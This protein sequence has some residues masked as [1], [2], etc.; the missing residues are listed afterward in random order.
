MH[1]CVWWTVIDFLEVFLILSNQVKL[2]LCFS[3]HH[4]LNLSLLFSVILNTDISTPQTFLI[5][6]RP[7]HFCHIG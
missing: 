2:C 7:E 6:K 1:V 3:P 4:I 5:M